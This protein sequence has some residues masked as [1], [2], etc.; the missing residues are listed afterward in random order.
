MLQNFFSKKKKT[1]DK[2]I[3]KI[4]CPGVPIVDQQ[5]KNPIVIHEKVDSIP[6]L[7]Q[8]IK[9]LTLAANL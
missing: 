5:V 7:A 1:K 2:I 8:W 6:G 4:T 3:I 9:D